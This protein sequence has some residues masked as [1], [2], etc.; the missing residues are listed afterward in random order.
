MQPSSDHA[1]ICTLVDLLRRRVGEPA[2]LGFR[3]VAGRAGGGSWGGLPPRASASLTFAELDARARAVAAALAERNLSGGRALLCYP[4]GLEFMVGLYASLYAGLVA[5]P[6]Y[7][8]RPH[9]PDARLA[10]IAAGCRPAVVLTT[11]ELLADRDRLVSQMPA[12]AGPPWLASDTAPAAPEGWQ[13]HRPHPDD[14]AVLQYTSGSTGD[15]KGV[16]LTH[17]CVLHNIA[18]I[19]R[20]MRLERG[21]IGVSWLPAFHDMGL[22][23]NLLGAIWYPG[24]LHVLSPLAMLQDPF[25]WLDAVSNAHAYVSGGPC[26]A[27]EQCIKR[28][29]PEQRRQLDLSA[30]K[31][32]YVGAEPISPRILD[33][34]ARAFAECGFK[35]ESFY[36]CFGLAE[37]SLMVTGVEAW[38]GPAVRAFDGAALEQDRAEPAEKGRSLVGSGRPIAGMDVRVVDPQTC[39]PLADG[40]I[41]EVWVRGPSVAAGY[42][43]RPEATEETFGGTLA[44]DPF[45]RWMRTGDLG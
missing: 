37:S 19:S 22:I 43:E 6:A 11:A 45:T 27:F 18:G 39:R 23:G 7:P 5:V 33:E 28:I 8:P 32:A 36:P 25:R 2:E 16:M 12:L 24:C 35:R 13:P 44:G 42:F 4:P 26:F 21:C 17:A 31:V 10:G 9:K 38:T 41:G 30:W 15:P 34:F 14:L 29:T 20:A 40:R 1:D 3:F